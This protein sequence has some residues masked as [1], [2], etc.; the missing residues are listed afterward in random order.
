[1]MRNHNIPLFDDDQLEIDEVLDSIAWD[2]CG[3]RK[4]STPIRT[5]PRPLKAK[6]DP[7]SRS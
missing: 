6:Q 1:M 3:H 4:Q 7:D 5:A 2:L